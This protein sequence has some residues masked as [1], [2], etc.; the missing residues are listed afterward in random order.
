MIW[1]VSDVL[2]GL[3]D[4][5]FYHWIAPEFNKF[6][7]K[8]FFK[9]HW[10]FFFKLFKYMSR[11]NYVEFFIKKWKTTLKLTEM[12]RRCERIGPALGHWSGTDSFQYGKWF[13]LS[14]PY[15]KLM[16]RHGL[17]F[18]YL[19]KIDSRRTSDSVAL[20]SHG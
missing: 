6:K 10:R 5:S 9:R 18:Y 12:S 3:G 8:W 16:I 14:A 19:I 13:C 2:I 7:W 17:W 11:F 1:L 20:L 15:P 4:F